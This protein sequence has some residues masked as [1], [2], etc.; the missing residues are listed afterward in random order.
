M[1]PRQG[2]GGSCCRVKVCGAS[3]SPRLLPLA[4]LADRQRHTA[5]TLCLGLAVQGFTG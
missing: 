1:N 5:R 3:P 4:T 2:V